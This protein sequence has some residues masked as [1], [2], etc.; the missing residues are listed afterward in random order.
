VR[1]IKV[2]GG[3]ISLNSGS[4][5]FVTG[6]DKLIQGLTLWLQEPLYGSPLH[7]PGYTTPNFGSI[8]TSFIG[9][10]NTGIT[11]ANVKAELF[12]ILGLYQQNQVLQL[13]KAQTLSVLN[14]WN[15]SEIIEKILAIDVTANTFTITAN[16]SILTLAN[17]QTNLNILISENGIVVS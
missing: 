14:Y 3:D 8:L 5:D 11:Q 12:R 2:D 7:G 9:N 10:A 17:V 4:L 16:I 13:Q 1:A 6:S 15:K